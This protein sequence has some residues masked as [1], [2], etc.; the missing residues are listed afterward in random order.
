MNYLFYL[1]III[2]V[3]T[4]AFKQNSLRM[5][6]SPTS[7][8]SPTSP[9]NGMELFPRNSY[10]FRCKPIITV[11]VLPTIPEEDSV[12]SNNEVIGSTVSS[13]RKFS[14]SAKTFCN[15]I[16]G[17]YNNSFPEQDSLNGVEVSLGC[18]VNDSAMIRI[19][20][21]PFFNR[22]ANGYNNILY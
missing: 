8:L 18:G 11:C 3:L 15:R 22:I 1:I 17:G 7:P 6:S 9:T 4:K 16:A 21:Q 10:S 5:E 19:P 14:N 2:Y 12:M 20:N 13:S